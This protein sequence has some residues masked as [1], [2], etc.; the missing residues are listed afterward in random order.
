MKSEFLLAFNQI[1]A[2]RNLPREIVLDALR[3]ALVSAYRKN[4]SAPST[5]NVTA[6]IDMDRARVLIYAER[7]VVEQVNDPQLE[8]SLDEA[9]KIDPKVQI[10]DMIMVEDTPK[11]FG[12]IAA[13]SARQMI[14]QRIREAERDLQYARYAEQEGE[15][16]Y[17]T[18]QSVSSHQITL[19][20]ENTE[21]I[22]PRREMVPG[23]RYVLHDRI[24][25]YVVEVKRTSR[26]P[27]II[28]SRSHTKMLQ[29]LLELE[30]PEIS[31]GVVEIKA[32][33]REAGARS[34]V[35]VYARQEGIDAVGACVGMRGMRIQS[36]V[37]ELGGEKVD[38]IEWSPNPVTFI[39]KA[40]GPAR[41]LSVVLEEHP[42]EGRTASV[43]VPDDQLSLA[44]G[45]MG[46]NARLAAKLTG[47]RIDIQGVTEAA[48]EVLEQVDTT[49][50]ILIAL[51]QT[52]ELLP[53]VVA[54]LRHHE[55]EG[56]PYTSEELVAMRRVIE[57]VRSFLIARRGTQ[58]ARLVADEAARRT[59]LEK[60]R[61][62]REA[63]IRE[64]RAQI[65]PQA[66]DILLTD[67]GLSPRVLGH[68]ERNGLENVGQLLE[69]LAEGDVGLLELDGI[70]A[71][72]LAEI[73]SVLDQLDL[74]LAAPEEPS[75]EAEA[76]VE[77][78][79]A[80][81]EAEAV[82]EPLA[83]VEAA[84]E[85]APAGVEAAV[86]PPPEEEA[87]AEEV[88]AEV[89][90]EAVPQ[91]PPQEEPE[92]AVEAEEPVSPPPV[93]EEALGEEEEEEAAWKPKRR[94]RRPRKLVYD[95]ELGRVIAV[96]R[97]RGDDE[98]DWEEF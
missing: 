30:V 17:G 70:G 79:P 63:S 64:A 10:G 8:I 49:P 1:C 42:V 11:N 86:E 50:E 91:A 23:E 3:T 66:F 59:A 41:I 57:G 78:V 5:Q 19:H 12:R 22:L 38:I 34:K 55:E 76:A 15:L 32:I 6:Q 77:E 72:S 28:V 84:A 31:K 82:P 89:E 9:R 21:A 46:Q 39:A 73:R 69:L 85:E 61:A 65:P 47:W 36:I 80:E 71:K 37:K 93:S 20:L 7:Q 75:V 13:Q 83:E 26:G 67:V 43:V 25:A 60:A 40:L 4:V 87:V 98:E 35:A 48:R 29:R 58:W 68:L 88:P 62:E 27:Q 92:E 24:R 56:M 97:H 2:E 81:A 95:E 90:A 16:V 53:M 14:F 44:I 94:R 52:A 45:R 51:G 96:R 54:A 33:A 18:V 74:P